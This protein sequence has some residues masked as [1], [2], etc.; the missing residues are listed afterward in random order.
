MLLCSRCAAAGRCR[1]PPNR[2]RTDWPLFRGN[3]LQ[4]GVAAGTLC[5]T[6]STVLWKFPTKDAID[7]APAVADGVVYVGSMDEHLYALDLATGKEKWKYKAGPIKA[8][9]S[10]PRRRWSTSATPT[11]L[12]HCVDAANGQEDAGPSRPAAR[13]PPAPTSPA[14]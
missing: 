13:S 2:P 9:P 5:P 7:G 11:A 1:S 8:S 4:T 10:L 12:F 3:P 6:S 14:T